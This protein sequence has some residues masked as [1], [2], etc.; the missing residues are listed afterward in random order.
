MANGQDDVRMMLRVSRDSG[1]TLEPLTEVRVGDD[2]VVP[3]NAGRF[4]PC[5]CTR[6]AKAGADAVASFRMVS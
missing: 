2:S 3:E 5:V 4:P 1:Q 6:C